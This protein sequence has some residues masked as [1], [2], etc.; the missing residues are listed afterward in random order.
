MKTCLV[1][2]QEM[3]AIPLFTS[4]VYKC[5]VCELSKKLQNTE[6]EEVKWQKITITPDSGWIQEFQDALDA[7]SKGIP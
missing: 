7:L 4:F 2:F 3:I 6:T 5:E 1:C